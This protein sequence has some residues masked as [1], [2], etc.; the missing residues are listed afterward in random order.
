MALRLS[1]CLRN[2]M[3][4]GVAARHVATYTAT[5]IAAVDGGGGLVDTFTDSANGFLTAGFAVGDSILCTGF[6]G[7]MQYI[8]GPFKA[9]IVVAGT[10]TVPTASLTADAAGESVTLVAL[11][12]GSFR[13]IF[14]KGVLKIYS[15]SQPATADAA[16]TGTELLVISDA[17]G[18]FTSGVVTNGLEFGTAASGAISKSSAVWSD[19]GIATGTAGY[20]RFYANATDAGGADTTFIYPRFDGAVGTSGAELNMSSISVTLGATT[21]VD[22]FTI[23]FPA[24]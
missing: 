5:T 16:I 1:T 2:K 11:V 22:T 18:A 12:G 19:V 15:G 23:T 17:G 24:S 10:I 3:L 8:V 6:T 13:D 20:F 4:D 21:T 7:G 14:K 9:S